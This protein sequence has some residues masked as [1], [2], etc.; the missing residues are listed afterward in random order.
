[1]SK[2]FQFQ[3]TRM[4]LHYFF[5]IYKMGRLGEEDRI[6]ICT[7]LLDEKLYSPAEIARKYKVH[8][9][10]ITRL[11]AKYQEIKSTKDL[12]K[13][14]RSRIMTEREECRTV[15]Y[16]VNKECSNAVQIQKKLKNEQ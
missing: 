1:M 2:M 9:S 15:R 16:I 11:Y 4:L 3:I 6:C 13:S 5:G 7:L 12:P 14:G 10:T 8:K